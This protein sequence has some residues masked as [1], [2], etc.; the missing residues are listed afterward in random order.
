MTEVDRRETA[1][2][3]A[4][5]TL[6]LLAVV[7]AA[8]GVGAQPSVPAVLTGAIATVL[9]EALAGR[10]ERTIRRS[11]RRWPVKAGALVL[12]GAGIAVGVATAPSLAL[13]AATGA[14]VA[15]LS[16]VGLVTAGVLAPPAEW[17]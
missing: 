9:A 8:L 17:T 10:H 3:A 2:D 12:A 4:L 15:Y 1:V 13:S 14:L 7:A 6:V 5:A 16:L 11:W